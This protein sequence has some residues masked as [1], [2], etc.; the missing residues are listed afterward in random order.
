VVSINSDNRFTVGT[1]DQPLDGA[2]WLG[3]ITGVAGTNEY[4]KAGIEAWTVVVTTQVSV[5]KL[6]VLRWGPFAHFN[7]A[8]IS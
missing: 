3:L 1:L 7:G 5:G 2:L 4:V 6:S 8:P